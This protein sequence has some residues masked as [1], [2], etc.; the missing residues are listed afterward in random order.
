MRDDETALIIDYSQTW[1]K[2]TFIRKFEAS[3]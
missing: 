3:A 1:K 2:K